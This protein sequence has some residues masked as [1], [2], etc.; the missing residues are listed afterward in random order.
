MKELFHLHLSKLGCFKKNCVVSRRVMLVALLSLLT[1]P[2]FAETSNSIGVF[3]VSQKKVVSFAPGNLQHE[4]S[5][6]G[7]MFASEQYEMLGVSNVKGGSI[8]EDGAGYGKENKTGTALANKV[9]LFGWSANNTTPL[10][11][12]GVS[13]SNLTN[14]YA[15]DFLDWGN[16]VID[17]DAPNTWRTLTYL[18]WEYLRYKRP[19]ADNLIAVARIDFGG[20]NNANGDAYV[21]GLILLPDN[22]EEVKVDC[23]SRDKFKPGFHPKNSSNIAHEAYFPN[24]VFINI[25]EWKQFEAVGAVFLPAGGFRGMNQNASTKPVTAIYN[26]RYMGQYWTATPI[27]E[28]I[29]NSYAFKFNSSGAQLSV[30]APRYGGRSVRLAQDTLPVEVTLPIDKVTSSAGQTVK[31]RIPIT[32]SNL[33]GMNGNSPTTITGRSSN[34]AFTVMTL[35]NVGPG[36]HE[37]IVHYTPTVTTDG[38]EKTTITLSSNTLQGSTSFKMTGRHLAKNFV[39]A[40]KVGNEWVALTADISGDGIQRALPIVVDD[41]TTPTKATFAFDYCQYQLLGLTNPNR[42]TE[43]GTAVYLYSTKVEK[44]LKA[45]IDPNT[46]KGLCLK[47]DNSYPLFSEWQ[48]VSQDL[49]HYTIINSNQ[50]LGWENNRTLGYS[51]EL[52]AWGMYNIQEDPNNIYQEIFLLPVETALADN[53]EVMEWGTNSM[54][55]RFKE[56]VPPLNSL[57][58]YQ[59]GLGQGRIHNVSILNGTSD[60]GR[61]DN[62]DLT[63]NNCTT[64]AI[65]Q[66]RTSIGTILRTPII[67]SSGTVPSDRYDS[68]HCHLCDIVVLNGATLTSSY[69]FINFANIY[70]YPGGKLYFKVPAD[71]LGA[72]NKVY[73]RGGYSWLNQDTYAL[74]EIYL[75]N[76]IYFKGS[77]NIIYDYYIKNYKYY[78]FALP[79]TVSLSDVSDETGYYDFPVWVKHYNGALRAANAHATSWEYYNGNAFEE[80]K[81]YIIAAQPRQVDKVKNRPL[82]I[83]RFPLRNKELDH[84]ESDF[85]VATTA[86]GIDGYKEGTVTD[87]NVGWNFVGNPFLSSWKGAIGHKQLI[88]HNDDKGQWDGSYDWVDS[89]VKY[90][91]VMSAENGYDYGQYIAKDTELKPFFP[92]FMQE[93]AD[94]GEGAINFTADYLKNRP[95]MLSAKTAPETFVQIEILTEGVEDQTGVFAADKYSDDIDFDDY[96]KIFGSST[97]KAKIWLVHQDRRMAFEAMTETTAASPIALGYRAPRTGH[98]TFAINEEVSELEDLLAV[99]LTDHLA[100]VVDHD[101]LDGVYEFESE[102]TIY[103]DN[104]FTVRVVL[105]NEEPGTATDIEDII[106]VHPSE[107]PCKFIYQNRMYIMR[108]GILYD[109]TGQHVLTINK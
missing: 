28:S 103:N 99:Y 86:H 6:G 7:W 53:L 60:L 35:E 52:D 23:P 27:S 81:G 22:W 72:I 91:T 82:S 68:D 39:I 106:G 14:H 64:I 10:N 38:I 102:S 61:I 69:D 13:I 65:L 85:S 46:K 16:N 19:N 18:E 40:T 71:Q 17:G 57:A 20:V 24:L 109:A 32:L 76:S 94:G 1:L 29:E 9:D 55:V 77:N 47:E 33:F 74:P 36:N 75:N 31:V 26:T 44:V 95:L 5:P 12:F 101:L 80:G 62:I 48:L 66:D 70:I 56:D 43:N 2:I 105:R 21:N 63:G 15:G 42:F 78:Q 88:K 45:S 89:D 87:N 49:V 108:N 51:S 30:D 54:I 50:S 84:F 96:E 92:F 34:S 107:S 79:Y 90:I 67:V 37:L 97:D 11:H 73:L 41:N 98:Y 4:I 8:S 59:T 93:A 100:G 58:I 25:A 83:I 3:F 104:R